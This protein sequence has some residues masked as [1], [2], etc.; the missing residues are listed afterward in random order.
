MLNSIFSIFRQASIAKDGA[1]YEPCTFDIGRIGVASD[2]PH[3][4]SNNILK[5]H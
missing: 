1:R 5:H 4:N 3:N 2:K